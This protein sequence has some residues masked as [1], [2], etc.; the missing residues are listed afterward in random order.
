MHLFLSMACP[1]LGT[2][3]ADSQLVATGM[4]AMLQLKGI[5]SLKELELK[6]HAPLDFMGLGSVSGRAPLYESL[7]YRLS[8]NGVLRHFRKVV[9]VSSPSDKYA[10]THSTRVQICKRAEHDAYYGPVLASMVANV[11][12]SVEPQRLLRVTL[13]NNE[14]NATSL[15]KVRQKKGKGGPEDACR[16]NA[17]ARSITRRLTHSLFPPFFACSLWVVLRI[18]PSSTAPSWRRSCC[19]RCTST[20]SDLTRP[21]Q[22]SP[23]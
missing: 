15:D 3:Y 6:D 16:V 8:E 12:S 7:V 10:P 9:L 14:G 1:H 4:W 22:P 2:I 17:A 13:D 21:D 19:T 23:D 5:P 18:F 11:L 20:S